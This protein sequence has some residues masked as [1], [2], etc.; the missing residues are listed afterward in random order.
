MPVSFFED[1]PGRYRPA[2]LCACSSAEL[3][4][5]LEQA[6][7]AG[8]KHFIIVSHSFEFL[9]NRR[10]GGNVSPRRRVLR[11]FEKLCEYLDR[12][13]DRFST[14]TFADLDIPQPEPSGTGS[15]LRSNMV[16]TAL[17][18]GEQLLDRV[19]T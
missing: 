12:N 16:R 18:M 10:N 1:L 8:W 5:A 15:M 3:I 4:W 14:A 19:L 2:Q 17:R 6:H 13:R 7:A 11:R 9:R